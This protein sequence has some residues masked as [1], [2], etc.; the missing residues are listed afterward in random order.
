MRIAFVSAEAAPYAKVGGL[1]DVA[2]SLPQALAALGH[3]V[4]A[5]LP[6]HRSLDQTKYAIPGSAERTRSVPY[7]EAHARIEYPEIVRDSVRTV[8]VKHARIGRDK[9]YGY[10]DDAKRYALFCRAV[11]ADLIDAPPD[12]VH[13]H[14]WHAALLVPLAAKARELRGS[15]TAV[16][17]LNLASQSRPTAELLPLAA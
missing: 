16:P 5:D 6:L 2:G 8:F 15:A 3:E 14:D 10:P 7:G 4:T 12:V 11:V 9:V 13:A 17:I 1:A